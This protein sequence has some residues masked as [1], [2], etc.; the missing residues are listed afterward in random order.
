MNKDIYDPIL[1]AGPPR[2]GSTMVTGLF[3]KHGVWVGECKITRHAQTNSLIGTENT[4]IKK[5]LKSML[6]NYKNWNVPLPDLKPTGDT[7]DK[8]KSL[9]D[10][11]A[12]RETPWIVKTSN[13]LLTWQ[14]WHKLFPN[15]TWIFPR[16][17]SEQII[18]S[19]K[20]HPVMGKRSDN[21]IRKFIESLIERQNKVY[22][23][24]P[25]G[26][27]LDVPKLVRTRNG[28]D[29][30]SF[31]GLKYNFRIGVAWIKPEMFHG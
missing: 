22:A 4:A 17:D 16:R 29:V 25:Y 5:G 13:L 2:C 6:G 24:V 10:D 23:S 15:A 26:Y 19:V 30:M 3:I 8:L 11:I 27:M 12:P 7:V 18:E 14:A 20:R 21:Q 28:K 1:V 9:I 31:A